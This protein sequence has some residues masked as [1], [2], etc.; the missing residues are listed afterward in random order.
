MP[1]ELME[2]KIMNQPE[3]KATTHSGNQD[4]AKRTGESPPASP[5]KRAKKISSS[6]DARLKVID[7]AIAKAVETTKLTYVAPGLI[8]RKVGT[9]MNELVGTENCMLL[10]KCGQASCTK[11]HV[12]GT[13]DEVSNIL[14]T[15]KPFLDNPK[16]I[17]EK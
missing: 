9:S 16:S 5:T 7:T 1:P 2:K 4:G 10:G 13:A 3:P 11:H 17:T 12:D 14:T 15:L 6:R 8:C